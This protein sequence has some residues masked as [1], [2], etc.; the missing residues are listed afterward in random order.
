MFTQLVLLLALVV[1]GIYQPA[2]RVAA[3]TLHLHATQLIFG[4]RSRS[5]AG[6]ST[7]RLNGKTE[8]LQ[9]QQRIRIKPKNPALARSPLLA[10]RGRSAARPAMQ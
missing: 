2:P 1:V 9:L 4:S 10:A 7:T 3:P 5:R 6:R 8:R